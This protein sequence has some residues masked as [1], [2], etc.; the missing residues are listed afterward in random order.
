MRKKVSPIRTAIGLVALAASAV[1]FYYALN[2]L[3][4]APKEDFARIEFVS[5]GKRLENL[6]AKK[7][8][9]VYVFVSASDTRK[10]E[11]RTLFVNRKPSEYGLA[12]YQ[13]QK[14]GKFCIESGSEGSMLPTRGQEF[15]RGE[16]NLEYAIKDNNRE[17]RS[18]KITLHLTP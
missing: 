4:A 5:G 2:T 15:T 18:N 8:D 11:S 6:T 14:K 17:L 7:G 9:N 1:G 10:P 12:C 3:P 13:D 16:N